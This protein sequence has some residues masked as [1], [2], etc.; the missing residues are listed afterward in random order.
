MGLLEKDALGAHIHGEQLKKV[1]KDG[2]F[3]K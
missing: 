2:G 1:T 3:E